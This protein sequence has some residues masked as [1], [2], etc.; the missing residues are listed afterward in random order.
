MVEVDRLARAHF[1]VVRINR[2]SLALFLIL[3]LAL[4]LWPTRGLL[5]VSGDDV[6][7]VRQGVTVLGLD[8]SGKT[9]REARALLEQ[10]A[11]G[12]QAE[13]VDARQYTHAEGYDYVVPELNGYHLDV[14]MTWL[15]LS[16]APP[17]A[18]VEPV[19]KIHPAGKR[20]TDFPQGVIRQGNGEKQAIALLVN[21]DWGTG[22]L[23]QMLPVLK[24][25]A[26][27]VTFFVSGRW[28]VQN[29]QLLKVMAE[30][31]HEIA[32]HGYNL[33]NG[34]KALAASGRLK[35]D[36][37]Q[38]VTVIRSITGQDVR[39]YAPHMSEI[40]PQILQTAS[41]LKLR[42]VLYSLDT[43]DWKETTTP[44]MI[45]GK[46]QQ[47]KAGDLIL[48]HPKPNT[49]KVLEQAINLVQAAGYELITLSEMLTPDP[50]H[51]SAASR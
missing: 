9:E 34:P 33:S 41:D 35:T 31:G 2:W 48:L 11:S 1:R 46:F 32:T 44:E 36:I 29:K 8:F 43:V 15:R 23:R 40:S 12:Y 39:Y 38:S 37:E 14:D 50:A 17:G 42:T 3:A 24:K 20:L 13:P 22:E 7:P 47:A 30:D 21:V 6:T 26:V 51:P 16:F 5:P 19:T 27:K 28:A 10:I 4:L 49:A 45:L 18:A 25:R